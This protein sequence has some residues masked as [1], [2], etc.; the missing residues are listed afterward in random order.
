MT[1]RRDT[2]D[3]MSRPC[4]DCNKRWPLGQM[5]RCRTCEDHAMRDGAIPNA[6]AAA[7]F[8]CL[9]CAV[10]RHSGH[11]LPQII[12]RD[13]RGTLRVPSIKFPPP[14]QHT[15]EEEAR[16]Q[17]T[18]FPARIRPVD[19]PK[20]RSSFGAL[21]GANSFFSPEKSKVDVSPKET[22]KQEQSLPHKTQV[23]YGATTIRR[24]QRVPSKAPQPNEEVGPSKKYS[25]AYTYGYS[26]FGDGHQVS[27]ASSRTAYSNGSVTVGTT[28]EQ[29]D[30]K[31]IYGRRPLPTIPQQLTRITETVGVR[32]YMR[33]KATSEY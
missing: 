4:D 21:F 15:P 26:G 33:K 1:L 16:K 20:K 8:V 5:R 24:V 12:D 29:T 17:S 19:T 11:T 28:S 6:N 7:C 25:G 14:P 10:D 31:S 27:E 13:G 18:T 9:G 30:S 3:N 22:E 23:P 2:L 32:S